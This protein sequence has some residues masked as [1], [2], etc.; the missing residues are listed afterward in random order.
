MQFE[1]RAKDA[2]GG[3]TAGVIEA[4]S[5]GEARRLIVG[6]DL[7]LLSISKVKSGGFSL[8]RQQTI[9]K[10]DLL[11]FT[12]QLSIMVRSGLDLAEALRA[13][14][15][16][17]TNPR[18]K[19][20]LQSLSQDIE[21]GRSFSAALMAQKQTFGAAYA[22]SVAAGEASGRL[23]EVLNRLTEMLRSEVRIRGTIRSV[24]TY[25]IVLITVASSVLVSMIFFVL[26][27]FGKVFRDLDAK[28]P[29]LTTFLLNFGEF[30]RGNWYFI[31]PVIVFGLM[32]LWRALRQTRSRKMIESGALQAPFLGKAMQHL[33]SGR[34]F[35]LLGSMLQNGVPALEA[36]QFSRAAT[37]HRLYKELFERCEEQL[38]QGKGLSLA[39]QGSRLIPEGA[40]EM[41]QTAERNG[42]LGSVMEMMGE[43]Y[44]DEGER[45]LR[46]LV[47]VIEPA[48]IV[49]MG[50]FVAGVVMSII[51]PLLDLSSVGS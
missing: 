48:I 15:R 38:L 8:R 51:L 36:I 40:V 1:Y 30:V 47:R 43:F 10:Q 45:L 5:L 42:D 6:R 16:Q 18:L 19:T 9:S 11:L 50:A 32:L 22:A 23:A 24:S 2:G 46:D 28:T 26:P 34:S 25:P 17:S 12:T 31:L 37:G 21:D 29:P 20:T 33:L 41:I 35:R 49:V 14:T 44:E 27:Q 13:A 7:F 3:T 4:P 39:M